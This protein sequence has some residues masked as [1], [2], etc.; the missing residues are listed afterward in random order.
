MRVYIYCSAAA[1]DF[2]WGG[3]YAGDAWVEE[4]MCVYLSKV[5]IV[6]LPLIFLVDQFSTTELVKFSLILI[7]NKFFHCYNFFFF[8]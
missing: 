6:K 1:A 8:F 4:R 7:V 5:E 2:F 3:G